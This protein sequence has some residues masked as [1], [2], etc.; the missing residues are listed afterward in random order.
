MLQFL[1][2]FGRDLA[3]RLGL[4]LVDRDACKHGRQ[5]LGLRGVQRQVDRR[6]R[7]IVRSVR[8]RPS[9][10]SVDRILCKALTGRSWLCRCAR[11]IVAHVI[12]TLGRLMIRGSAVVVVVLVFAAGGV[13]AGTQPDAT[14]P[15][16]SPDAGQVAFAYVDS[17]KFRIVAAPAVG[18]GPIRTIYAARNADGCCDPMQWGA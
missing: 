14:S 6:H 3:R 16:W 8:A 12:A 18:S 11:P 13:G 15:S 10:A 17:S 5:S 1:Q 4:L 9:L 2:H 7:V